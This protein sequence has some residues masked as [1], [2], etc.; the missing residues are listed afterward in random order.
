[1]CGWTEIPAHLY[2]YKYKANVNLN[3]MISISVAYI[4]PEGSPYANIDDFD[5]LVESVRNKSKIDQ[6]YIC[7][8]INARTS[9]LVDYVITGACDSLSEYIQIQPEGSPWG[10]VDKAINGYGKKNW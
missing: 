4:P 10:N 1:M 5:T 2:G 8:D 7:G 3:R 6:V 9:E